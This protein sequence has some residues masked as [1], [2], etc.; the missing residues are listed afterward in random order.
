MNQSRVSE[1]IS[2]VFTPKGLAKIKTGQLLRFD[3]EGNITEYI[4][5]KINRKS[6]KVWAREVKTYLPDETKVENNGNEEAS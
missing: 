4:I 3:Y 2:E 1:D 5:T 6:S